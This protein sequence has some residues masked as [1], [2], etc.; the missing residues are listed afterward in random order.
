MALQSIIFAV[1]VPTTATA[2][3]PQATNIAL[4]PRLVRAIDIVVP[5]GV[6]GVVGFRLGLAGQSVI[7]ANAGAWDVTSGEVVHHELS[8][9]PNSGA[10]QLIAYNSGQYPHTLQVRFTVDLTVN[11]DSHG[12]M[13]LIP[14]ATLSQDVTP[15]EPVISEVAEPTDLASGLSQGG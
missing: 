2:A 1:T 12:A 5:T 6:N 14:A 7:P 8:N 11:T 9:L 13:T 10:W 15:D 4:G 3:S